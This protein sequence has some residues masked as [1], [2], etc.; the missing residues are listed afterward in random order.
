MCTRYHQ[1][2]LSHDEEIVAHQM[3]AILN[4]VKVIIATLEGG[5]YPTSNLVTPIIGKVI[6]KLEPDKPTI[7]DYRGKKN[8]QSKFHIVTIISFHNS[9]TRYIFFIVG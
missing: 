7:T 9:L 6:D 8:Y 2:V 4:P 1:H 3:V 5:A